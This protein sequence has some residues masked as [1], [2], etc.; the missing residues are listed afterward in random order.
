[1]NS[2]LF[3]RGTRKGCGCMRGGANSNLNIQQ[4][5]LNRWD[6]KIL[7]MTKRKF[8][9]RQIA[10]EQKL[11]NEQK[12][13]VNRLKA[14][15]PS[16]SGILDKIK[17]AVQSVTTPTPTPVTITQVT[18]QEQVQIIRPILS[19][20]KSANRKELNIQQ[21][22]VLEMVTMPNNKLHIKKLANNAQQLAS[23][24]QSIANRSMV[25]P[26]AGGKRRI[27]RRT[28]RK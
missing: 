11:R 15:A 22:P 13:L 14:S 10:A 19:N 26:A 7:N 1:M 8:H 25:A 2:A 9:P 12:A 16:Q 18:P 20:V 27:K 5:K 21:Q 17:N 23:Q 6:K 4:Q 24:L 28:Y 3:R